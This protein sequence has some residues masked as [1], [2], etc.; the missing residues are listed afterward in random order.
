MP[1]LEQVQEQIKGLGGAGNFIGRRLEIKELPGILQESEAVK[2]AILGLHA[3]RDGLLAATGSRLIF[4]YK[5]IFGNA[6]ID[7]FPY[8]NI[9][10]LRYKTGLV[11]GE[12][13]LVCQ[14][15]KEAITKLDKKTGGEFA[16]KVKEWMTGCPSQTAAS[17]D[18]S[19]AGSQP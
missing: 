15:K 17:A 19:G 10:S 11:F 13:L 18:G 3:G 1:T 2:R 16:E 5:G 14:G 8:E 6:K 9:T 7:L 4:L 12:I